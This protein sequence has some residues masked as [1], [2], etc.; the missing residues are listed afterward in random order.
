MADSCFH[1]GMLALV[2]CACFQESLDPAFGRMQVVPANVEPPRECSIGDSYGNYASSSRNMFANRM[3]VKT[4][5]KAKVSFVD[6]ECI[7]DSGCDIFGTQ[8]TP[9]E[10]NRFVRCLHKNA[11]F[12][13]S[14]F[15]AATYSYTFVSCWRCTVYVSG[16]IISFFHNLLLCA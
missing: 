10:R 7:S 2:D 4:G 13:G 15:L 11:L 16:V 14:G 3:E 8:P 6:L 9:D 1:R 5:S 12:P